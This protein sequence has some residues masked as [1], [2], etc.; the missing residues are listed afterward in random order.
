MGEGDAGALLDGLPTVGGTVADRYVIQRILAVGGMG[1]VMAAHDQT[2]DRKVA[3]KFMLPKVLASHDV[4]ARFFR[5][6]RA[7]ASIRSQHVVDVLE[8]GVA[9]P[10][11]P[12]I[13]MEFL[14]GQDLHTLLDGRAPLPVPEAID[15]VLQACDALADAHSRGIV[16][17]D[18]KPSNFFVTKSPNGTNM[19]KV[20]DFGISKTEIGFAL[21][22]E[23]KSLTTSSVTLGSPLYMSPEQVRNS[24]VVDARTDIWSLGVV[25]YELLTKEMPFDGDTVPSLAAAIASDRP[26]ALRSRRPD[27]PPELEAVIM[28]CLEK[29]AIRRYQDVRALMHDL[30]SFAPKRS[31]I[32]SVLPALFDHPEAS[33][34]VSA[35]AFESTIEGPSP[36]TDEERNQLSSW[37]EPTFI[38]TNARLIRQVRKR[39]RRGRTVVLGASA[40]VLA[41]LAVFLLFT[42]FGPGPAVAMVKTSATVPTATPAAAP[43]AHDPSAT[44]SATPTAAATSPPSANPATSAA[45]KVAPKSAPKQGSRAARGKGGPPPRTEP[46]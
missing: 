9:E 25:L 30:R 22:V 32:A 11:M 20:L 36:L 42:R 18:V 12:F 23:S 19:V 14:D 35:L 7:A 33:T 40:T 10:D 38:G 1:A 3:I 15:Y 29:D 27:V 17:R 2:Q 34:S 45:I 37:D 39:S 44:A 4:R 5:E 21:D 26:R 8:V 24:R 43:L 28:K 6:A 41:G 31:L 46:D 13:V 16:H